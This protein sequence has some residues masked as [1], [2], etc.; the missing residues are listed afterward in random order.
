M[1]AGHFAA[2]LAI[3]ARKPDAPTAG[4]LTGAVFLDLLFGVCVMAGIERV[5]MTP[6]TS[7]GFALDYI[8]W[9]HSLLMAVVWSVL[10]AS[11]FHGRDWGVHLALGCAVFS[12]FVLDFFMHPPDLALWPGASIH[13]GLGIWRRW[14]R[15]GW[16]FELGFIMACLAYYFWRS[17]AERTFG[18]HAAW[19]CMVVVAL[20]VI[21]SPWLSPLK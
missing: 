21:N 4:L 3:K 17:R 19:A 16:L 20:H 13:M 2:G 1:Y 6:G 15:G 5:H 14:P 7:P 12:H 9:S 10:F 8:D 18:R 11:V